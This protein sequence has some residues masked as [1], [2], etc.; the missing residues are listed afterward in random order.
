MPNRQQ[1]HR[2]LLAGLAAFAAC[3]A[4]PAGAMYGG[5]DYGPSGYRPGG[6]GS[7][8]VDLR[9]TGKRKQRSDKAVKVKAT[10]GP[11]ECLVDLR[12]RLVSGEGRGKLRPKRDVPIR[13]DDTE[14]VKLKLNQKA[15]RA[16]AAS[17][18]AKV[19]VKG[20]AIGAGGGGKDRARRTFRL[21]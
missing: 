11:R 2:A 13:A 19:T 17:E 10:C 8:K 14:A 20:K 15:K 18:R 6:Y 3:I 12:G 16:A 4:A 1:T 7:G 21:I 9:I 5:Y